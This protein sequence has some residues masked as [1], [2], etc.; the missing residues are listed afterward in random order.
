V[1]YLLA[2]SRAVG[3]TDIDGQYHTIIT[4]VETRDG[5]A[6]V[7]AEFPRRLDV[8]RLPDGGLSL[9]FAGAGEILGTIRE[10][11]L[12]FRFADGG[13][14]LTGYFTVQPDGTVTIK[15]TWET[16]FSFGDSGR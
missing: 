10:D 3:E 7:G 11:T 12:E 4:V 5:C 2:P 6:P 15:A 16:S 8:K 14:G 13:A 9:F 1:T